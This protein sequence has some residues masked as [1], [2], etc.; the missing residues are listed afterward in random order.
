MSAV[1]ESL[2]TVTNGGTL[3]REQAQATLG[4]MMEG[5]GSSIQI[6]AL[7]GALRMRGETTEEI[8]GFARAMRERAVRV[9]PEAK[10]LVD[11]C[12]TG[13]DA[14]VHSIAT[15]N[16]STAASFIAAGAGVTV[17]KHGNRAMSSRCGSA[18]V[19]EALGVNLQLGPE[20]IARCIDEVGIGFMFAQSHHPAMKHVAPI[21]REL[22]IRTIFNLLGPL[23]N[24]AGAQRQVMGVSDRRWI[25]PIA[26]VLLDLG[27]KRAIV[28]HS[29]DGMDEFS[30]CA[31][32]D[33][34]LV[35]NGRFEMNVVRPEELEAT[36]ANVELLQGGD[37]EH[38]AQVIKLLLDGGGGATSDIACLNAA[39]ILLVAEFA[40]DLESGLSLAR[41]ALK[42][43][44]ARDKLAQLVEFSN[45][46]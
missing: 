21:R 41:T 24:P 37:A 9:A 43:G 27:V 29:R 44:A 25:E 12:G 20:S 3:S 32:T 7:L 16:I 19:L 6:A 36:C 17:A 45:A 15:F 1:F 31:P 23:A 10:M 14:S 18:D 4:E 38:N 35:G 22:G 40:P 34:A 42:T 8:V 5:E 30:T 33:Y 2:R 28:C 39:A 26:R 13:G 11:T 46:V